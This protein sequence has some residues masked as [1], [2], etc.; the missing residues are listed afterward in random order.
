M[1]VKPQY[2]FTD[3]AFQETLSQ[4]TA[5]H[6]KKK[7]VKS[8]DSCDVSLDAHHRCYEPALRTL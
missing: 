4:S 1:G 3:V 8:A 6:L 7:K 2:D 5:D